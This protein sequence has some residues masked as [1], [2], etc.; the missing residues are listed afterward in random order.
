MRYSVGRD[1]RSA[2]KIIV[3]GRIERQVR[4]ALRVYED[5]VEVPEI[6]GRQ[7]FG[8]NALELRVKLLGFFLD[9]FRLLLS[10]EVIVLW[11]GIEAA[12]GAVGCE[13][14]RVERVLEDVGIFVA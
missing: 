4:D 12:V 9:D 1:L 8:Q 11:I 7:V 6:D 14:A 10:V 3:A 13:L 5:I 2:E